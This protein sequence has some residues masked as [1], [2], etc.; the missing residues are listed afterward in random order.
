LIN[1][2]INVSALAK[3]NLSS[4]RYMTRH[5]RRTGRRLTAGD[6]MM[7]MVQRYAQFRTA[8]EDY[9]GTNHYSEAHQT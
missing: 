5:Y 4:P 9:N 8:E 2:G 7:E 6:L 1:P 3:M